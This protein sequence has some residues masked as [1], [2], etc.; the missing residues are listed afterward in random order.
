MCEILDKS[1]EEIPGGVDGE[2]HYRSKFLI[3]F[4]IPEA[5]KSIETW[6]AYRATLQPSAERKKE[7]RIFDH[8]VVGEKYPC[9]YDP[10]EP[11]RAALAQS[12]SL[13]S[14]IGIILVIVVLFFGPL[15]IPWLRRHEG[16]AVLR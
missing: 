9:W 3:R 8:F 12:N 2:L 10:A 5:P 14:H 4:F 16:G 7:E 1:F 11:D 15:I 13:D 6:A